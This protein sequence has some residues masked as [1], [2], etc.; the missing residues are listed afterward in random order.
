[1]SHPPSRPPFAPL[2]GPVGNLKIHTAVDGSQWVQHG[3]QW[4]RFEPQ[5]RPHD[6]EVDSPRYNPYPPTQG[7]PTGTEQAPSSRISNMQIDPQLLP[8]PNDGDRDLTEPASIARARGLVPA[9]K[10]AGV[11]QVDKP[12]KRKRDASPPPHDSDDSDAPPAPKRGRPTGAPNYSKADI[13]V[14]LDYVQKEMPSGQKGWQE[15]HRCY[16]RYRRT[17]NRPKRDAKSLEHKYKGY[18]KLK[19]PT[20]EG[21][22]P[23][24]VNDAVIISDSSD[25][26]SDN[27]NYGANPGPSTSTHTAVA[28]RAP[29]PPLRR[30][31]K[32]TAPDLVDKLSRAFDPETL[33]TREEERA[34]RSEQSSQVF[35]L[36]QQLR[37]AHAVS[38]RLRNDLSIMQQHLHNAERE[39]DVAQLELKMLDREAHHGHRDGYFARRDKRSRSRSARPHKTRCEVRYADGGACTYFVTDDE[40]N[41]DKENNYS[42][43]PQRTQ[44]FYPSQTPMLRAPPPRPSRPPTPGPSRLPR[45]QS[46]P[47]TPGPSRLPRLVSPSPSRHTTPSVQGDSTLNPNHDGVEL[48]VT[49]SRGGSAPFSFVISGPQSQQGKGKGKAPERY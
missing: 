7:P 28:Q 22:C 20:G 18:L 38:E 14:L 46:R 11:R 34:R 23:P 17:N 8:I 48:M 32:K 16:D 42:H 19:K 25:S 13:K 6:M 45:P 3:D 24:E 41:S 49:P 47:P 15:V 39:R 44:I 31:P 40:Y 12:K 26:S 10:V 43:P 21:V 27:N 9:S 29:T 30:R 4:I 37:D 5:Q 36:S 33:R 1:M 2:P 35:L